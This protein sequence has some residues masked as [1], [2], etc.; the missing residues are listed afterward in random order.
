M[1]ELHVADPNATNGNLAVSW[2]IDKELLNKLKENGIK[3]AYVVI[4]I[5][6][7][8]EP[9]EENKYSRRHFKEKEFRKIV[10]LEDLMAYVE[11]H[12]SGHN[13]IFAYVTDY[14]YAKHALIKDFS[15]FVS[16]LFHRD[17][18]VT[19]YTFGEI[20][21]AELVFVDVPKEVFAPEPSEWEK[22]WVN[23]L[24]SD[25]VDNQ[26]D[27]RRRR[28]FAYTLQVPIFLFGY[29]VATCFTLASLLI[30]S[31]NFSFNVMRHPLN[32]SLDVDCIHMVSLSNGSYFI[33]TGPNKYLNYAR[34]IFMP[35]ILLPLLGLI[36]FTSVYYFLMVF[37]IMTLAV[38]TGYA[39]YRFRSKYPVEEVAWYDDESVTSAIVCSGNN[40]VLSF[41]DLPKSRKTLKLRFYDLKAKV[42]RPFSA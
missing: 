36:L 11:L 2:C 15:G 22:S 16:D 25:K 3:K 14:D 38:S 9:T 26:C 27:F 10:P 31:K 34:M 35:I 28:I 20:A 5:S 39:Y 29:L 7:F 18:S 1:F 8:I 33:G 42:C 4:S 12:S 40:K 21:R 23:W 30:G 24:L 37:A 6:P 41:N 32:S 19:L 17:G 13:K